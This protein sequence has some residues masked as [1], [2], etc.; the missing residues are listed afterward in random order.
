MFFSLKTCFKFNYCL[1]KNK[2]HVIQGMIRLIVLYAIETR[3]T[4][5]IDEQKVSIFERKILL[6]IFGPKIDR[7][8]D[9]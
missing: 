9:L 7:T 5:K 1:V 4:T 3:K 2:S 8:T 6:K